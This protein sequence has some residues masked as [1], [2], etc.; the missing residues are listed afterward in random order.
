[1][2]I[3]EASKFLL[4]F[5]ND[6]ARE[7]VKRLM[8]QSYTEAVLEHHPN[9]ISQEHVYSKCNYLIEETFGQIRKNSEH[10]E[11]II[12]LFHRLSRVNPVRASIWFEEFD[13]AYQNYKHFKK[14]SIQLDHIRPFL[15]GNSY[16]DIGCGGG[17]LVYFIKNN[18]P[19]FK[20]CAGIDVIDWRTEDV[21]DSIN[22]QLLDLSQSVTRSQ[23]KYDTLTCIA[24]LHHVGN[25]AESISVFLQN[26]KRIISDNGRLIIEEDVILPISEIQSDNY[27]K[28]QVEERM[29]DQPLFSEFIKLDKAEQK[30]AFILIDVLANSLTGGI[31]DMAFPF[32]FKTINEWNE[33]FIENGFEIEDVRIKGFH[34]G[35]FNRSSHVYF[36][37]NPV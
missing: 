24:V 23:K 17:D 4:S 21:K 15:K 25:T 31:S 7:F 19:Q 22:F 8:L 29:Q 33:L 27:Y 11:K 13:C 26:V 20:E 36:I 3:D 18:Y 2:K 30:D 37:L 32:G 16:C 34:M 12:A 28:E 6:K 10:P 1:M 5:Q 9:S 35:L 14:L